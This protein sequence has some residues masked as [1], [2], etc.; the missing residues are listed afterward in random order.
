MMED[1][2]ALLPPFRDTSG[3]SVTAFTIVSTLPVACGPPQVAESRPVE[4]H[5][6][7]SG[8]LESPTREQLVQVQ[9]ADAQLVADYAD[10][11]T[12]WGPTARYHHSRLYAVDEVLRSR[13][14][15]ALLDVGCGPGMMARHLID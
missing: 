15:G 9:Y 3:E 10:A 1:S 11:Y 8:T 6:P 2:F 5:M 7:V 14:G 12:G 13:P 4:V